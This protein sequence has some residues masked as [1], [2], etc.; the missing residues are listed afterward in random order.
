MVL[1]ILI[2]FFYYLP[3]L[4]LPVDAVETSYSKKVTLYP[5]ADSYVKKSHPDENFGKE[6]SLRISNYTD[7]R[8]PSLLINDTEIVLI[9]F[10]LSEIPLNST[11]NSVILKFREKENTTYFW[12]GAYNCPDNTWTEE[13]VNWNNKPTHAE[14]PTD[15][16]EI[17]KNK[18]WLWNVTED[19]KKVLSTGKLSIVLQSETK[20]STPHWI[21]FFSIDRH[22]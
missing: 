15:I 14:I 6:E 4:V 10:D 3:N 8:Y 11:I 22:L 2:L 1:A 7:Q 13:E 19:V 9:K 5:I 21:N 16:V 12:I 18:V 20:D 17:W